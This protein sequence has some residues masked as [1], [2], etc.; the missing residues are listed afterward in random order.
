MG[1][2]YYN[3]AV[4]HHSLEQLPEAVVALQF[5]TKFQP[6]DPDAYSN[7]GA[8]LEMTGNKAAAKAALGIAA[9]LRR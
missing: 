1:Q 8:T 7:L 9:Q 3:M 5:A 2:V 4:A 6:D